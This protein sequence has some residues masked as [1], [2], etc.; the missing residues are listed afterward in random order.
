MRLAPTHTEE[1]EQARD[2]K[3]AGTAMI[4]GKDLLSQLKAAA[5]KT[6]EE[7]EAFVASAQAPQAG[8]LLKM[9]EVVTGNRRAVRA[10]EKLGFEDTG[11]RVPHPVLPARQSWQRPAGRT[12]GAEATAA[13]SSR[14]PTAR[15]P[16]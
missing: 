12:F 9:L 3:L 15:P 2:V 5:W 11:E 8:D 7:I 1:A 13:R 10:Y 14:R 6:P 16:R 4:S